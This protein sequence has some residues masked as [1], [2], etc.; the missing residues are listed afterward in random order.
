M[1]EEGVVISALVGIQNEMSEV[2]WSAIAQNGCVH[3]G[4]H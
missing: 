2:I 3:V 1:R 4:G